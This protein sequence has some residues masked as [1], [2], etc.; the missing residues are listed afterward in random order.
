MR[1]AGIAPDRR[2][3]A[4]A[5][6]ALIAGAVGMGASPVF[7]RL[8]D[9]GPFASAFWRAFLALPFL[10][11][12]ARF[13][14]AGRP[15]DPSRVAPIVI[16]AGLFFTGDLLFWHLAIFGTTVANATFMAT[17][18]PVWVAL[19]AWLIFSQRIDTR[20]FVALVLC[21][22]GGAALIR[23]SYAFVP[24]RLSGDLYGLITALFFGAYTVAVGIARTRCGAA[25]LTFLVT[26]ITAAC[27]LAIALAVEPRLMPRSI[28]GWGWLV[29]LAM[30]S[31]VGGQGLFA[32]ALGTLPATFSSLV[33][34]LET[35][36][37]ATFGWL[38]FDEALG[39]AQTLG[40]VLIVIGIF[41]ARPRAGAAL[42]CR[43]GP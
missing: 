15:G 26:A 9:V 13:E 19:G 16:L 8:A 29:A 36:A 30:I 21:L 37:A 41:V 24:H 4:M 20:T 22:L 1:V 38:V 34:F 35:I 7:V 17:T 11:G 18:A 28:A 27:L 5:Y 10:W 39:L 42:S 33:I 25:R 32:V 31:Q 43:I 3:Q 2:R 6:L 40:G 14:A 23:E 12:W